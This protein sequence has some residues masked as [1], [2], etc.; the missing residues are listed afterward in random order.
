MGKTAEH[1]PNCGAPA[2][3]VKTDS[4]PAMRDDQYKGWPLGVLRYQR[5]YCRKCGHEG[6]RLVLVGR[7]KW[8]TADGNDS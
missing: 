6:D 4:I 5:L 2:P 1:C 8:K 3:V 7:V